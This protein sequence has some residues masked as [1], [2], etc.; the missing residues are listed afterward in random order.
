MANIIGAAAL[1]KAKV[2]LM[3]DGK[4]AAWFARQ[5][6]N[7]AA[8]GAAA[9]AAVAVAFLNIRDDKAQRD[10]VDLMREIVMKQVEK[11]AQFGERAYPLSEKQ[12]AVIAAAI[13][14]E[15]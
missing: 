10:I 11:C 12:I 3:V 15:V 14:Q 13:A 8:R 2:E 9:Q 1:Y 5:L 4:S 7:T 6:T